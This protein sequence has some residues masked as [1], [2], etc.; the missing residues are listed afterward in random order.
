MLEALAQTKGGEEE[1]LLSFVF[2]S[3][4]PCSAL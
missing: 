2:L 4:G 3:A 1:I